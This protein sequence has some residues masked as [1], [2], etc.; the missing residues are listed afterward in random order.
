MCLRCRG[1]VTG[2]LVQIHLHLREHPAEVVT[3]ILYADESVSEMHELNNTPSEPLAHLPYEK[4]C[5]GS[6]ALAELQ[7]EYR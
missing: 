3:G 1:P 4:L 5:P 2:A 6:A 7:A